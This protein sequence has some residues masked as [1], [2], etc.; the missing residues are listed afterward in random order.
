MTVGELAKTHHSELALSDGTDFI[1]GVLK[2]DLAF[3][4]ARDRVV[5]EFER[6][7]VERVLGRHNGNVTAAA[8]AS[9]VAYRYFQLVRARLAR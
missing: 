6:R 9:G 2:D 5:S 3:P 1:D 8:R 4:A 7:Y